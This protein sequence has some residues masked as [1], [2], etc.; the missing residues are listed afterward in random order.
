MKEI[1]IGDIKVYYEPEL[2]GGG[3]VFGINALK[4]E[5]VKKYIR[6]GNVLEMCSGPSFM[7]FHL[8]SEGYAD[9][10]VLSELNKLNQRGVNK[11]IDEN[12]LNNIKFVHSDCF[13]SHST[14]LYDTIVCNPPHYKEPKIYG[15][16]TLTEKYISFDEEMK[17]HKEFLNS[18]KNFLNEKGVV[19]LVE[20]CD[21]VTEEDIK[22][23]IGNE[24][25]VLYTEYDKYGWEGKSNFYTIILG[26]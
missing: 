11:T 1:L 19:I 12:N 10:L 26:I 7:G 20:N 4:S 22:N 2:D 14:G 24:Y 21:G 13:K 23:I 6:K 18:A 5:N 16:K 8:K 17:F 9:E 25:K 3:S 15:Y